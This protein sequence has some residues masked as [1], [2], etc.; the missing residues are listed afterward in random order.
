MNTVYEILKKEKRRQKHTIE[1]IASENF[2]SKNIMKIC[3][4]E[5]M[6]KYT[7]GYPGNRYYG[8][9]EYYDELEIYCQQKWQEAF[10]TDYYV[11]VQPHSGTN[12]NLA[13]YMAVLKPGDSFL[14]MSLDHGGHLSHGSPVNI[15]GKVFNVYHYG[16][17][18]HGCID[19]ADLERL[20]KEVNPKLVVVGASAY[21]RIIDFK[22]I[23]EIIGDALMMADIAHIAGLVISHDH[24][25]PFG[26]ADIVTTTTQKT[27]RGCRGGLIFCK[28]ELAKKIDSAV[29]PGTQGGSLMNM[30]AGKAI[31]AEEAC[32]PEFT[33]YI[34]RVVENSKAMCDVFI[35]HGIPVVTGGT[36]NH[37]FLLD[38]SKKYPH[39]TG[40]MVQNVCDK[41][42]ITLNK[43][44]IPG[45]TR[46]AFNT[47]G[48][49]IGTAAM[50]TR[51]FTAEDFCGVALEII[52]ICE[53][54]E[55]E[56]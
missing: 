17:D 48:V 49:R 50:T 9:C 47:S 51:G 31:T 14:S 11:N 40:R 29:F 7:E 36:D 2:P 1:L 53:R 39:V 4:T 10:N 5:F 43:N 8:G 15:S 42:S 56:W 38:L 26:I 45:D 30:I 37:L 54:L 20:M 21:P 13:A 35:K 6:N 41:H 33:E 24:P 32:T 12:A 46:N 34:H 27:L 28:P 3:G 52:S 19:Y 18:E 16:V 55:A 23:R 22:K 44:M 25:S